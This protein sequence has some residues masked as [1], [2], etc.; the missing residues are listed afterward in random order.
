MK[1]TCNGSILQKAISMAEKAISSR[2]PLQIMENIFFE[3]NN[4]QL[5]IRGNDLELSIEHTIPVE[6]AT[7][8]GSVL[9]KASTISSI[10]SKME[11]QQLDISVNDNKKVVIKS[12]QVDFECRGSFLV[13]ILGASPF[14]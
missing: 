9:I 7:Q 12:D 5:K 13:H 11:N 8:D 1:F 10:V 6:N 2:S 3:L 4:N 14:I